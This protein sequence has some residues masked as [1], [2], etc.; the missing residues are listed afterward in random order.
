MIDTTDL[1]PRDDIPEDEDGLFAYLSQL[2]EQARRVASTQ[3]NATLAIRNWLMGRAINTNILHHTR[4]DYGKQ[5]Y[6]S[7]TH[8]LTERFGRGYD[9]PNVSRMMTFAQLYPDYEVCVLLA[10]QLSWTHIV[11]RRIGGPARHFHRSHDPRLARF[12]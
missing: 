3:A 4:A 9:Q 11:A 12:T 6:V 2:V 8:K 5:I 10:H 7:L 1:I